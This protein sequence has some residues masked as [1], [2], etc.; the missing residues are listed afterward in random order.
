MNNLAKTRSRITSILIIFLGLLTGCQTTEISSI[1]MT[2]DGNPDFGGIWQALGSAHYNIEPHAADFPPLPMLGAA[3]A[4]PAGLGV[5]VGETIPYR[6]A[7]R[8]QQ[9]ANKE[10][11]LALDPVAKCYMPGIPRANYMPFPFQIIQSS[12]HIVMAYEFASASRLVYMNRPDFEAPVF[13]WMG[14]GRGRFEGNSLVID[15]TD[16]VPDTWLDHAGNHH[17]D[18]LQVTERYTHMGPNVLMY[19]AILIDPNVYTKPWTIRLPLYRRI[20][21]NMQLLEF[22][23]V[24]F[25]EELMYGHLSKDEEAP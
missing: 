25:A 23:C 11:W 17:T 19:E 21:E 12:E 7:A 5:V 24:E 13:S 2:A 4:V 22:K 15:V 16:Q 20:D 8:A 1:P 10:N 9:K 14:H 18:A 6:T 3:G